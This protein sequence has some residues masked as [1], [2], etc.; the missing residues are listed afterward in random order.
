M[1]TKGYDAVDGFAKIDYAREARTGL[2]EVRG[3]WVSIECVEGAW[4]LGR[5][6]IY[7]EMIGVN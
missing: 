3:V 4:G 6:F 2:P 7:A 1:N 5:S